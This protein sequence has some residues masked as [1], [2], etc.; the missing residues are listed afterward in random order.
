MNI[1]DPAKRDTLSLEFISPEGEI[2]I[3]PNLLTLKNLIF[4]NDEDY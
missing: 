2:L 1:L 3:E 4:N